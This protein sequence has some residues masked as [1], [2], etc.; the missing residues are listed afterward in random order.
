M[1]GQRRPVAL[2]RHEAASASSGEWTPLHWPP[3]AAW[4]R[5]WPTKESQ[6]RSRG[7]MGPAAPRRARPCPLHLFAA[8]L[9]LKVLD[10]IPASSPGKAP[11]AE[12]RRCFWRLMHAVGRFR[13][14]VERATCK[15]IEHRP[16][17]LAGRRVKGGR[18]RILRER[19]LLRVLLGFSPLISSSSMIRCDN[20]T[21]PKTSRTAPEIA[22]S[23][24][25][26]GHI[27]GQR[28]RSARTTPCKVSDAPKRRAS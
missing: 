23:R 28:F 14:P 4:V 16:Q 20:P 1:V 11:L 5:A 18:G 19:T 9:G 13:G 2:L 22:A 12:L 17:L 8:R 26:N 25:R 6:G 7:G 21:Y 15:H 27:S 10:R 24:K 3:P